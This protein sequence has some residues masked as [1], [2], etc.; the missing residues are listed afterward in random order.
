[1]D[2][3]RVCVVGAGDRGQVHA[4]AWQAQG[5]RVVAVAD[6]DQARA[7]AL[8]EAC[9]ARP[10][11]DWR[12]AVAQPDLDVV[13]V[14]VPAAYHAPVA[15]AAM[16]AGR[17]VL[18]EKPAALSLADADRMLATAR[19]QGVRLGFFFQRRFG[20]D[21]AEL[22]RLVAEGELGRPVLMQVVIGN[23]IRPKRA[24]HDL[25][26]NA[27]PIV[28][29]CCH[30]FDLWRAVF[31]ADPVRV[32]ATGLTLAAGR[33][34]LAGIAEV[35]PDTAVIAVDY[36]SGDVGAIT[37]SWGL[38]PG[39]RAPGLQVLLGPRG[40]VRLQ[41]LEFEACREGAEVSRWSVRHAQ[42]LN[43]ALV[44]DFAA[45][46][47]QG[48]EPTVTGE[49]GRRALAVS[50]GALLS[51]RT[52]QAVPVAEVGRSL[53]GDVQGAFRLPAAAAS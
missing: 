9:G 23:T 30:W 53:P 50:L 28:D 7:Q 45:A 5:A 10:F 48:R 33:P 43:H 31:G 15:V 27:G 3:L 18:C 39:V 29:Y 25:R 51:L 36:A 26:Q 41:G 11:L 21:V 49:D 46:V 17:H 14:C 32:R 37:I 6:V 19:R 34:E 4:R 35:A 22:R 40:S 8:A 20:A 38:P 2:P 12:E 42:D 52:G 44:Q 13:S 47:A 1:M 24:M 16:E